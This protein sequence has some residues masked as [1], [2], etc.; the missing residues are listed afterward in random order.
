MA[1]AFI[2]NMEHGISPTSTME[3]MEN[4][5]ENHILQNLSSQYSKI[6]IHNFMATIIEQYKE[7]NKSEKFTTVTGQRRSARTAAMKN[8]EQLK[9]SRLN[10]SDENIYNALNIDM[11]MEDEDEEFEY[12]PINTEPNNQPNTSKYADR[13]VTNPKNVTINNIIPNT[14]IENNTTHKYKMPPIAKP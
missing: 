9:K 2:S 14:N 3:F 12:P 11:E 7:N 10:F 6:E 1:L 8:Q 4:L 5:K 13:Q